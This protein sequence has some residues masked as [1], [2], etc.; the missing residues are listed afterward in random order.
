MEMSPF[1][2]L[3]NTL[4]QQSSSKDKKT[5]IRTAVNHNLFT[6]EQVVQLLENI[7]LTKDKLGMLEVLRPHISDIENMFQIMDVFTF[8][9]DQKKASEILGQPEDVEANLRAKF[10]EEQKEGC[11]KPMPMA[12]SSFSGL[13]NALDNQSFSKEQLYVIE[14]AAF[15]NAFTAEQ[16]VQIL[17]KFKFPRYRLR[18]LKILRYRILDPENYFYLLQTFPRSLQKKKASE[19]LA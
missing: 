1:L 13:L 8:A 19:L 11:E 3:L 18:A 10:V 16:V 9:K 14:L 15:R 12:T 17:E 5:L 4:N 2:E 7:D 6:T